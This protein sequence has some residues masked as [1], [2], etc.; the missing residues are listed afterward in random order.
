MA[1][2]NTIAN[3]VCHLR[4]VLYKLKSDPNS[5]DKLRTCQ[6]KKI[7][8]AKVSKGKHR[9]FTALYTICYLLVR[10]IDT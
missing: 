8:S 2:L 6:T 1:G 9:K 4:A 5:F 10:K 3:F 7:V